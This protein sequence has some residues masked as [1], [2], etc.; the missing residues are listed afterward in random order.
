MIGWIRTKI[1]LL[2]FS[3]FISILT[4]LGASLALFTLLEFFPDL[5]GNAGTNA[6]PYYALRHRY[7]ADPL[8]IFKNKSDSS[9]IGTLGAHAVSHPILGEN[10]TPVSYIAHFNKDGFRPAT[11]P[12]VPEIAM[13]GDSFIEIGERDATTLPALLSATL[14]QPVLNLG[15]SWYGP[16][17]YLELLKRYT[18][19]HKPK[20]VFFSF[21]AGNDISDIKNFLQFKKTG[22]YYGFDF[23]GVD[24]LSRYVTVLSQ[25]YRFLS[26]VI[27]EKI[28]VPIARLRRRYQDGLM[29]EAIHIKLGSKTFWDTFTYEPDTRSLE[30]LRADPAWLT[31]ATILDTVKVEAVKTNTTVVVLYIPSKLEL[32]A[33]YCTKKSGSRF[34]AIRD[35]L[36]PGSPTAETLLKLLARER[37]LL[38]V[39]TTPVL[40]KVME[41]GSAP[42]YRYDTHWNEAGRT[43][44]ARQLADFIRAL[45][46]SDTSHK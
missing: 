23:H 12:G 25:S 28:R 33:P 41:E 15:T 43:A 17:Q 36:L 37:G 13:I 8:L 34:T 16:H 4:A 27:R 20:I 9:F 22:T 19:T 29:G 42:F 35:S 7:E 44:I 30:A 1:L 6:L 32:Y 11:M 38:F 18:K 40:N 31:L 24:F 14:N 2:T 45:P 3:F 21:F 39:S 10:F 26:K 46:Q 5:L